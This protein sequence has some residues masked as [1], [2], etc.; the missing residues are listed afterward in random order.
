MVV[1]SPVGEHL[2]PVTGL[3]HR[4]TVPVEWSTI[5]GFSWQHAS[6]MQV[7][8]LRCEACGEEIERGN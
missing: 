3:R 7:T 4:F 2:C 8:R 6:G 1:S 5:G